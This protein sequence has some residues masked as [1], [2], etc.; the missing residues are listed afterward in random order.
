MGRAKIR[1]T[2]CCITKPTA[3]TQAGRL[4]FEQGT[5]IE[6]TEGLNST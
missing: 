3:K 2:D 6:Q 5:K 4:S 1:P